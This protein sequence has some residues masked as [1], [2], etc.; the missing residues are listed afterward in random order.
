MVVNRMKQR[1]SIFFV[2]FAV[3]LVFETRAVAY[4][5]M[6]EKIQIRGKEDFVG[7]VKGALLLIKEKAPHAWVLISEHV[8]KI[9][10]GG[11]TGMFPYAPGS[12]AVLS[13]ETALC[14]LAWCAGAIIH[15]A[16]HA[17]LYREYQSAHDASVPD[18][19]WLGPE[20]EKKCIEFQ[21]NAMRQMGAGHPETQY[22][23]TRLTSPSSGTC[24]GDCPYA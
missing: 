21:I 9:E 22:W 5:G 13:Q 16:F 11:A 10:E 1:F 19:A 17:K 24:A 20:T 12:P 15:N 6:F 18:E 3:I 8:K 7:R 2:V 23:R 14:S 4:V